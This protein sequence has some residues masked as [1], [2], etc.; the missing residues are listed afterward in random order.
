MKVQRTYTLIISRNYGHPLTLSMPSWKAYLWG[1]FLILV[2][3]A[4]M[5]LSLLYLVSY[6]STRELEDENRQLKEE[7]DQLQG[8]L[9]SLYQQE[10]E[11]RLEYFASLRQQGASTSS[12]Q[13][14]AATLGQEVYQSPVALGSTT[15]KMNRSSLEV[16]FRLV[17]GANTA[18]VEG[19][20][21]F[22]IFENNQAGEGEQR[23]Y[24]EPEVDTGPDGFPVLYKGG[25]I[26]PR[27][28]QALTFRRRVRMNNE[29]PEFSHVTLYLFSRRGGLIIQQRMKLPEAL[30]EADNQGTLYTLETL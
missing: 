24:P 17:A 20:F 14:V 26:L 30:Y 25:L 16:A 28:N 9:L 15:A 12:A 11:N 7:R 10:Y 22:A 23:Y 29:T 1:M 18:R 8:Q 5:V 6:T 3:L 21:L 4:M 2:V 27:F 19:G 13:V